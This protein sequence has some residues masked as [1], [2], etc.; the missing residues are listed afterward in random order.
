MTTS[1]LMS[2]Y[3]QYVKELYKSSP[4]ISPKQA[5]Q[6]KQREDMLLEAGINV[7]HYAQTVSHL[8]MGWCTEKDV[9]YPPAAVFLGQYALDKYLQF[10]A[11]ASVKLDAEDT[12]NQRVFF[13]ELQLCTM[14]FNSMR[15]T[16]PIS[17]A[18]AVEVFKAST[19]PIVAEEWKALT[20]MQREVV[21]L[22]VCNY[23]IE[24]GPGF[25]TRKSISD[26]YTLYGVY[27]DYAVKE[28]KEKKL[29]LKRPG[30]LTKLQRKRYSH[31][32]EILSAE[33]PILEN[34]LHDRQIQLG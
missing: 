10:R 19:S 15:S 25:K 9:Y 11:K 20:P 34:N 26:Y 2:Y 22:A 13:T 12:G 24:F 27:F 16:S 14:L 7:K 1:N 21:K 33:I 28:L 4:S 32:V 3:V 8:L 23:Y 17:E 29:A 30:R 5:L 18:T 31:A 6:F